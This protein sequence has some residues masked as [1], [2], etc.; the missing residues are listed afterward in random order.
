MK[1]LWIFSLYPELFDSYLA[2]GLLGRAIEEGKLEVKRFNFRDQG[3]GKHKKVD[4]TPYGG[5]AGMVLRPEP[6]IEALEA[7]ELAQGKKAHRL[8]ITPRAKKY[9]QAD[10]H[11]LAEMDKPLALICGRFEGFDERICQF[12]DEE[13]SLGD[14]ILM[15]GEVAA[16]AVLESVARLLPEVIGNEASLEK[17][18]FETPSLEHAQYTKPAE[19]RGLSVPEILLSGDHKKIDDW[20]L[21]ESRRT[22]RDKRP[23]LLDPR[24]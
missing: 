9:V 24:P 22:T 19:F 21:D 8:L 15:G 20:R 2:S 6:I 11:R 5:G 18:S 12:V 16:M 4:D 23:D 3:L 13:L 7:A 17:E 10:A 14:Y 1:E